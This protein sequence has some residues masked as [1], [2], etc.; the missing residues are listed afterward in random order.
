M[1]CKFDFRKCRIFLRTKKSMVVKNTRLSQIKP[2]V[3]HTENFLHHI[4][5]QN[6]KYFHDNRHMWKK[7]RWEGVTLAISVTFYF[8]KN[9]STKGSKMLMPINSGWLIQMC[10]IFPVF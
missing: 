10:L 4:F 5:K 9:I 7:Y 8:L 3:G 1:I 6:T 2:E